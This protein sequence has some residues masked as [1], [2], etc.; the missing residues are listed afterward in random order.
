MSAYSMLGKAENEP[1]QQAILYLN[2]EGKE[3]K[4]KLPLVYKYADPVKGEIY[5][6]LEILPPACVNL[7]EPL[8]VFTNNKS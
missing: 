2:I 3:L 7:S 5:R 4:I 8:F 1:S 6:P